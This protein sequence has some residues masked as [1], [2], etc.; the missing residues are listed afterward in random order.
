MTSS[1]AASAVDFRLSFCNLFL[2]FSF[3]FCGEVGKLAVGSWPV[4]PDIGL[5]DAVEVEVDTIS[6][7]AEVGIGSSV[8]GVGLTKSGLPDL[9]AA[10]R[11]G[12]LRPRLSSFVVGVMRSA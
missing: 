5:K 9:L 8:E 1:P 3:A 4:G 12:N 10:F 6:I 2:C 7:F 11:K